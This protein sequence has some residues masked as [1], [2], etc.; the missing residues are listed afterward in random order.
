MQRR[1]I[2]AEHHY[3]QASSGVQKGG[4]VQYVWTKRENKWNKRIQILCCPSPAATTALNILGRLSKR[5]RSVLLGVLDLSFRS[6][7]VGREGLVRS[8]LP[9]VFYRV[10]IQILWWPF[11]F[12]YIELP[13]LCLYGPWFVQC[14][15]VVLEQEGVISKLCLQNALVCW[16]IETWK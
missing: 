3:C 12:F 7:D 11:K 15:T 13:H 2:K 9:K 6:T 8:L 4:C 1:S 10:D 16:S 5:F 14:C